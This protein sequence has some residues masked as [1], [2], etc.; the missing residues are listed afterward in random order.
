MTRRHLEEA[1]CGEA[2]AALRYALFADRAT[3]EGLEDIAELFRE[4]GEEERREHFR[5]IAELL[6]LVRTTAENLEMALAGEV[7]EHRRLYPQYAGGA[8]RAGDEEIAEQ[9]I[10]LGEDEHRHADR[11]R[12][13]LAATEALTGVALGV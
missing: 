3:D 6:G 2:L 5:E 13:A 10:E 1:L 8:R 9:F 4:I 7:T 12:G 11:L